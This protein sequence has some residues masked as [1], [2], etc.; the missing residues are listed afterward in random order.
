V[1]S[2]E[3]G[4]AR[5]MERIS[6]KIEKPKAINFVLGQTD[7]IKTVE[8][9]H[10]CESDLIVVTTHGY[11]GPKHVLMGSTDERVVHHAPCPVLAVRK[12]KPRGIAVQLSA[13]R[14]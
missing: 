4:E 5:E 3:K 11:I 12:C 6:I 2:I 9:I 10:D 1:L 8:D 14:S 13:I 7:F